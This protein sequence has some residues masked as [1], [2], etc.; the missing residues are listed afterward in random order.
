MN[1]KAKLELKPCPFCGDEPY[2]PKKNGG[3][4][5]RSGY[6]FKVS[7]SCKCGVILTKDSHEN[8]GG[9]CVDKGEAEKEVVEAWN[10]R[11]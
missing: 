10:K 4:D 9:W 8:G 3:S 5:E 1:V 6:N 7:I 11:K 2:Q